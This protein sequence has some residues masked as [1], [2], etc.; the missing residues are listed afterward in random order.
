MSVILPEQLE[1]FEDGLIEFPVLIP[2]IVENSKQVAETFKARGLFENAKHISDFGKLL[3]HWQKSKKNELRQKSKNAIRPESNLLNESLTTEILNPPTPTKVDPTIPITPRKAS[4]PVATNLSLTPSKR[5][6]FKSSPQPKKKAKISSQTLELLK[7]FK[8]ILPDNLVV[9][10]QDVTIVRNFCESAKIFNQIKKCTFLYDQ[11]VHSQSSQQNLNKKQLD[12][13]VGLLLHRDFEIALPEIPLELKPNL[14]ELRN[15]F[16][17]FSTHLIEDLGAQAR[18]EKPDLKRLESDPAYSRQFLKKI[19]AE[20]KHLFISWLISN[21]KMSSYILA[22]EELIKWSENNDVKC[23]ETTVAALEKRTHDEIRQKAIIRLVSSLDMA[24]PVLLSLL[25]KR[26][27]LSDITDVSNL[28]NYQQWLR[29]NNGLMNNLDEVMNGIYQLADIDLQTKMLFTSFLLGEIRLMSMEKFRPTQQSYL[30]GGRFVQKLLLLNNEVQQK[31]LELIEVVVK[32]CEK[33]RKNFIADFNQRNNVVYHPKAVD[34]TDDESEVL[35]GSRVDESKTTERESKEIG[36]IKQLGLPAELN[37]GTP[38]SLPSLTSTATISLSTQVNEEK[39]DANKNSLQ[40]TTASRIAQQDL[41]KV[42]VGVLDLIPAAPLNSTNAPDL[43]LLKSSSDLNLSDKSLKEQQ[44]K[45]T[46]KEYKQTPSTYL[47]LKKGLGGG[48]I[49]TSTIAAESAVVY[50]HEGNHWNYFADKL[51]P[52]G[53]AEITGDIFLALILF[54][55]IAAMFAGGISLL[56]NEEEKSE[57]NSENI[58]TDNNLQ[59][60]FN[61][62]TT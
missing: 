46:D 40:E 12:L 51:T 59:T 33:A 57:N 16:E 41:N 55:V 8:K 32:I 34:E 54:A 61:A 25:H 28:E 22:M 58:T 9:S 15:L 21:N 50:L 49:L 23:I 14:I 35:S 5:K 27:Q 24:Q 47:N 11:L 56:N 7:D 10:E 13:F 60:H 17:Q 42:Q 20:R 6:E 19:Y 45:S 18:F 39:I 43:L 37:V 2:F 53:L 52:H 29:D 36:A 3:K 38:V 44:A 48:I 62:L 1:A 30:S 31:F 26:S 4:K